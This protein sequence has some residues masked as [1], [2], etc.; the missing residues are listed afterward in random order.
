[1]TK[2][3]TEKQPAYLWYPKDYESDEVVKLLSYEQQGIYRKLLD[4]QSLE[5]SIPENA[6]Q[7][8]TLLGLRNGEV[9][10]FVHDLWPAIAQK[11]HPKRRAA[12]R[13]VNHRMER[14]RQKRVDFLR[15]SAK[16]GRRGA[17]TRWRARKKKAE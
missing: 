1:M 4:H 2:R 5:G 11:F 8:A 17:K 3:F 14:E 12:G 9:D 6:I 13:L 16:N 10:R 15:Q 7:I